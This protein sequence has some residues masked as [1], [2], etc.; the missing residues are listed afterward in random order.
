MDE[1]TLNDQ[2]CGKRIYD[3]KGA[4][5][6]ANFRTGGRKRYR[7]NR[8]AFLRPYYCDQCNGWHLTHTKL[9]K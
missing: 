6:A 9:I 7:H 8:P 5:T 4:K 2:P 3:K 1:Q